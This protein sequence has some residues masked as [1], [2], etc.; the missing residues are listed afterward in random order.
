MDYIDGGMWH[1]NDMHKADLKRLKK[2]KESLSTH[3][4]L[5]PLKALDA[6]A[7]AAMDHFTDYVLHDK[8]GRCYI[9]CH[10]YLKHHHAH[11]LKTYPPDQVEGIMQ[12]LMLVLAETLHHL[13]RVCNDQWSKTGDGRMDFTIWNKP[14]HVNVEEWELKWLVGA[15][16]DR[17]TAKRHEFTTLIETQSYKAASKHRLP[18]ADLIYN[19]DKTTLQYYE[20]AVK[21]HIEENGNSNFILPAG[22]DEPNLSLQ[23]K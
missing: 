21:F 12:V 16:K 4:L 13:T 22:H 6:V 7:K 8:D 10:R 9:A 14:Q 19:T 2:V 11:L 23:D 3:W 15:S 1:L 5:N 17:L 20:A 18:L